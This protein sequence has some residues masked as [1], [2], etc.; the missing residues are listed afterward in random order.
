VPKILKVGDL[1][2]K[3][4]EFISYVK[5]VYGDCDIE[6]ELSAVE[7]RETDGV[8]VFENSKVFIGKDYYEIH[9]KRKC[10]K[11][12]LLHFCVYGV[13]MKCNVTPQDYE[14]ESYENCEYIIL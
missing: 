2:M 3:R 10:G 4:N 13:G 14:F 7:C 5:A 6:S 12:V 8:T 9:I 1:S 11:P